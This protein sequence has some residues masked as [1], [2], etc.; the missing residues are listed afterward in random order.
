M[1]LDAASTFH[2]PCGNV[3]RASILTHKLQRITD[4]FC[5]VCGH[6]ELVGMPCVHDYLVRTN[7]PLIVALA[8]RTS[9]S[10]A[11]VQR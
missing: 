6:A 11:E 5:N 3:E 8:S 7:P 2:T 1:W 4:A 9:L 10:D